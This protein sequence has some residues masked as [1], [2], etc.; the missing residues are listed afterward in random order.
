MEHWTDICGAETRAG[1]PC[2]RPAGWGTDRDG[3]RCKSHGG[4]GGRPIEHGLYAERAREGL[5]ETIEAAN[6]QPLRELGDEVALLRA[7]L[8]RYL[9]TVDT[10]DEDVVADVT[11]LV[12]AVRRGADT[13]SK[14]EARTALTARHVEFLQARIADILKTYVP[15]EDVDA[16]LRDLREAIETDESALDI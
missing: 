3:G 13:V 2:Q 8:S 14:M 1:T 9:E 11:S 7:L 5:Q 12:D 10:V 6:E 4:A 16:A 15:A